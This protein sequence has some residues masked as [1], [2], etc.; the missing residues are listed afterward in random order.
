LHSGGCNFLFCDGS[1]RLLNETIDPKV[2]GSH[3][4]RA[5]GKVISA[6]EL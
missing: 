2:F 1:V 4:T 5:G 3:S 6:D